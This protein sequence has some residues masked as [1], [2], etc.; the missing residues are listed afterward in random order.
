MHNIVGGLSVDDGLGYFLVGADGGVFGFGAA[1]TQ[2]VGSLP[3]LGVS[4]NDIVAIA[5]TSGGYFLVGA[6]GGVFGFGADSENFVGSL[7]GLHIAVSDIVGIAPTDS[8]YFL[9]GADGG[10]FAFGDADGEFHGSLPGLGIAVHN[11]LGIA[12]LTDGS[13]YYLVGSD[14]GVFAFGTAQFAGSLSGVKTTPVAEIVLF[15]DLLPDVRPRSL[16][17]ALYGLVTTNGSLTLFS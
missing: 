14:G 6:D 7:P 3:Q 9:V 1:A 16:S 11:I 10:V 4:V 17:G 15:T 5:V 12:V 2:F 13:G 8:G